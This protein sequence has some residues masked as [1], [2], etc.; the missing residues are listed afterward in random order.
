MPESLI[1]MSI[2]YIMIS[3]IEKV[4]FGKRLQFNH[5]MR[6]SLGLNVKGKQISYTLPQKVIIFIFLSLNCYVSVNI[7]L[8]KT[9]MLRLNKKEWSHFIIIYLLNFYQR[10][11]I[12]KRKK[13]AYKNCAPCENP[14]A[15]YP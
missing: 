2:N 9:K 1:R 15:L 11:K 12:G 13:G 6:I 4:I 14:M 5:A 8:Y 3:K 10:T 7:C